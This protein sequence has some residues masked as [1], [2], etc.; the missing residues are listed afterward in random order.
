MSTTNN[1][2]LTSL[3]VLLTRKACQSSDEGAS[4]AMSMEN[5]HPKCS[6]CVQASSSVACLWNLPIACSVVKAL[7]SR[8]LQS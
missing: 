6:I 4:V 2:S 1:A 7:S 5:R 3:P 8:N